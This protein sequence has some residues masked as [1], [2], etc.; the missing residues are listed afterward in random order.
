[1]GYVVDGT[2][3]S[4]HNDTTLGNSLVN[5]SIAYSAMVECG[6]K[7]HI[8]VA[9]DDQLIAIEGDFDEHALAMA[10]AKCGIVPEYRKFDHAL[11]V[12]FI[13]GVWFPT[14]TGF[15]FVPKP[16]RLLAKLFWTCT[17]PSRIKLGRYVSA[18][19]QG[20]LPV[21]R[22]LPIVG[23]FLESHY[24]TG[25]FVPTDKCLE[26]YADPI[27]FD[28]GVVMAAF[29]NKYRVGENDIVELEADI[30]SVGGKPG[31][32][33]NATAQRVVEFDLADLH[34]RVVFGTSFAGA[35]IDLR[36][37]D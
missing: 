22:G 11:D 33:V 29:C 30:R 27:D 35:T 4:G 13:S 8:L 16:G 5:A 7:G 37:T 14:A 1:M 2:T 9:G 3:K 12:S 19:A 25:R 24:T 10:Q 31:L 17:P 20:L 28:R 6:L 15:G 32:L 23:P 34:D 21:C 26:K 18:V 36:Q